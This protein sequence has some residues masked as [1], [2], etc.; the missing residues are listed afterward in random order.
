MEE[1]RKR[2]PAW[3][4]HKLSTPLLVHTNTNDEDVNVVEV[5]HLIKALQA[6]GKQFEYR[7][8]EELPGGHSFNRMDTQQAR[9]IRLEIY[10]FLAKYLDPPRKLS[11]VKELARVSY[12]F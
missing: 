9:E 4:A 6:E 8:Y 3:N 2:S 12:K 11:T 10:D 5:E 7:I 1:Y